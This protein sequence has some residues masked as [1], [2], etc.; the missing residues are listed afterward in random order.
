MNT[1]GRNKAQRDISSCILTKKLFKV[2]TNLPVISAGAFQPSCD[3]RN[4]HR[5]EEGELKPTEKETLCDLR[6]DIKAT[7]NTL[8]TIQ[9]L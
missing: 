6:G 1:F 7:R 3:L 8:K 5:L 2:S 9:N 4:L